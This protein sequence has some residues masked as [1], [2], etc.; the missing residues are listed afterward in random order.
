MPRNININNSRPCKLGAEA[1]SLEQTVISRVQ[2]YQILNFNI[3]LG[4]IQLRI[5][6]SHFLISRP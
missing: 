2:T 3:F 6:W 1:A 4:Y 5:N